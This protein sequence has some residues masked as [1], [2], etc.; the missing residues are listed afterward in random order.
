MDRSSVLEILCLR[1]GKTNYTNGE[2]D[3]TPEGESHVR[4]V[5]KDIVL[6]W[7]LENHRHGGCLNVLSS[8][9]PRAQYTAQCLLESVGY[10]DG[11]LIEHQI[12]PT[13]W[14]DPKRALAA[15]NGLSGKGYINYETEPV[16]ADPE[17]FEPPHAVRER[18]Y[19]FLASYIWRSHLSLPNGSRQ[20]ALFV[21]HY[22]VLCNLVF[23]LFNISATRETE[24]R[25]AEPIYLSISPPGVGGWVRIV[26]TFRDQKA[27]A[28]FNLWECALTRCA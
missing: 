11:F 21:S 9:A 20:Y 3:L 8:P 6:P 16:F 7:I 23:D 14:R 15:C 17:V 26:G 10:T 12:G 2:K 27:S 18:W 13:L 1:H 24:L 25:H 22:E 19:A 5:G 4:Q 28:N